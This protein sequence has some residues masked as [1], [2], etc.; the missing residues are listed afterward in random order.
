[1]T[2]Q[3]IKG[4][5]FGRLLGQGGMAEVYQAIDSKFETPVAIKVLRPEYVTNKNIRQ[6]FVAEARNM[7]RMSHTNIVKVTDLIEEDNMVAFVMEYIEGNSLKN[8]LSERK[9]L[10]DGEIKALFVQIL[11]AMAYVHKAGLVHRDVKPSNFMITAGRKV[12]LLDFG[13][14]KNFESPEDFTRTGTEQ[15]MGTPMYMSPEQIK[16]AKEAK[17]ASDIYSLGVMLWQMVTGRKPYDTQTLSVFDIQTKIVNEALSVTGTHWDAVIQ[18]ATQ[19]KTEDRYPDIISL[20]AAIA[21]SEDVGDKTIIVSTPRPGATHTTA[22]VGNPGKKKSRVH[23]A[24][25]VAAVLVVGAIIFVITRE[26][27]PGPRNEPIV[28]PTALPGSYPQASERALNDGDLRPLNSYQLR[29]MRNEIYARHGYIFKD[30][31]MQNFFSSLPWYKPLYEDVG[32]LLT[33]LEISNM[34]MIKQY[35]QNN[36]K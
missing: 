2:G 9:K 28:T 24:V 30:P 16:S 34:K 14:A 20:Q 25:I 22:T 12:K 23:W 5:Q 26:K 17:A 1:M 10:D 32:T 31:E 19:K 3:T 18:R 6:R 27:P 36:F 4:Y 11:D 15:S 29:V 8:Y 35:E 7:F 13:I 33:D 21:S